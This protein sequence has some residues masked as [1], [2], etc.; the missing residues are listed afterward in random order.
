MSASSSGVRP[1][2]PPPPCAGR[3]WLAAARPGIL[4]LVGSSPS[5]ARSSSP[6]AAAA[7]GE[8][9]LEGGLERPPVG[10]R[11]HQRRRQGVL[12]RLAVLERDVAHRLGGVEVLG[13]RHRHA[14]GPQL[15]DEARRGRRARRS[16]S[17]VSRARRPRPAPWRR[18]S[19]SARYLS[20][21]CK[22]SLGLLGVDRLDA[23]HHQGAGPVEGL[24]DRRAPSSARGRAASARCGPSGRPARR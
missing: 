14:G 5:A 6:A 13:Q 20:R 19:M 18:R 15:V 11:L 7:E 22:V 12:E 16:A 8:V 2:P 21:M 1:S 23:E 17:A 3:P 10:G 4:E 9:H 24:G